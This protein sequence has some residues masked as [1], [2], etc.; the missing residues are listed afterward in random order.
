MRG[1]SVD[2]FSPA[3]RRNAAYAGMPESSC[4]LVEN[5]PTMAALDGIYALLVAAVLAS[6]IELRMKSPAAIQ[7]QLSATLKA[8]HGLAKRTC[9]SKS[10]KSTTWP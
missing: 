5:W 3:T 8:G 2:G 1:F 10:R 4:F 6:R 9:R 7:I